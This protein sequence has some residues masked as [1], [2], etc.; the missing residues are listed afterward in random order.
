MKQ[1]I[2]THIAKPNGYVRLAYRR[3]TSFVRP[4]PDF[5][6]I[7]AQKSGTTTLYEWI[8]T[9]PRVKTGVWKEVHFFDRYCRYS[10]RG[11]NWYRSHFPI[12][13]RLPYY[14]VGEATPVYLF[15]PAVPKRVANIIPEVSLVV[16][17]RNPVDRAYSH[18]QHQR[19]I[20][21]ENLSFRKAVELERKRISEDMYTITECGKDNSKSYQKYSYI[22]RGYYLSQIKN[23][24][25]YFDR[26]QMI[27]FES[28]KLFNYP[29][30]VVND[31]L[32]HIGLKTNIECVSQSYN[33]GGYESE[34]QDDIRKKLINHFKPHN[35]RLYKF[36]GREFD[37]D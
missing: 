13:G 15:N 21:T 16:L 28:E 5:L 35:M 9:H 14:S 12:K 17:L 30:K 2:R 22:S 37:W 10:N 3:I 26:D 34:M 23:W 24:L 29:V 8:S 20:G 32:D 27:I 11:V 25:E 6:I 33:T 4:L 1:K 36:L 19:R 31:V 18:Y 7:G